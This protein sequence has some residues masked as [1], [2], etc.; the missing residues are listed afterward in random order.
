MSLSTPNSQKAADRPISF[1]L[2]AR[3]GAAEEHVLFIR[4]EDLTVSFPSKVSVNQTLGGA[5]VDSFGEGLEPVTITGTTG[6]RADESGKDGVDRLIELRENTYHRWHSQRADAVAQGNDPDQV[7]LRYV[8]TLNQYSR[9]IV[10]QVFEIRRSRSRPLLATFRI[11]FIALEKRDV[12][13]LSALPD[14]SQLGVDSLTSSIDEIADAIGRVRRW[15]DS[16]F[17]APVRTFMG[18]ANNVLTKVRD[19]IQGGVRIGGELLGIARDIAYTGTNLFRTMAAFANLQ[20]EAKIAFMNLAGAFS[21]AFCVMRNALNPPSTYEDYRA[22]HGSSNCSS[23][24]GGLPPSQYAGTNVFYD[25]K[26]LPAT[27]V[28]VSTNASK[29]LKAMT[30]SDV[31][32]SPYPQSQL[33][34]YLNDINT[35]VVLA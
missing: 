5:W 25:V 3:G 7:K 12:S 14:L 20:T 32:Q 1:V 33:A 10:P 2:D 19:T 24:A 18:L 23:T 16:T 34:S 15:V 35:G 8:D 22:L 9:V 17:L 6:W 4:P 26:P 29:A 21:N 13:I 30:S 11:S 28:S 27:Q 31:V